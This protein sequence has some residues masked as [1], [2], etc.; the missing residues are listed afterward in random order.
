MSTITS[1][2]R[3]VGVATTIISTDYGLD[4]L[5]SPVEGMRQYIDALLQAGFME[6]EISVMVQDNPGRLLGLERVEP[7]FASAAG[8]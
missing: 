3:A 7:T 4:T 6:Q 8:A 1:Q 2:I 5:P